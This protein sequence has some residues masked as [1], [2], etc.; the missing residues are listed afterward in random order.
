M[1]S[2]HRPRGVDYTEERAAERPGGIYA[3]LL[4]TIHARWSPI[5]WDRG[6]RLNFDVPSLSFVK[7]KV[8]LGGDIIISW[9]L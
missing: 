2:N 3:N 1:L 9:F 4:S 5:K 6:A 8:R 7:G